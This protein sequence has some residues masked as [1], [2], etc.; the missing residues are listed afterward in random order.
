MMYYM[1]INRQRLETELEGTAEGKKIDIFAGLFCT[2]H[3]SI[4]DS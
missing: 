1:S 3:L 2:F 4:L